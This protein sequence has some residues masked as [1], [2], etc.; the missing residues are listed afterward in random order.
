MAGIGENDPDA[1]E[2]RRCL[3]LPDRSPA[4]ALS[5]RPVCQLEPIDP[6]KDFGRHRGRRAANIDRMEV[7]HPPQQQAVRR[8]NDKLDIG[9]LGRRSPA[10]SGTMLVNVAE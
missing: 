7:R 3:V 2:S 9:T 8:I 6:V 10:G 4:P 5:C 1:N